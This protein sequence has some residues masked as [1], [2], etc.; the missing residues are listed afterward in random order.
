[1]KYR[2]FTNLISKNPM[3][4]ICNV[5]I[6]ALRETPSEQSEMVNQMLFGESCDILEEQKNWAKIQMHFDNCEGWISTKQIQ[7]VSDEYLATRKTNFITKNYVSVLFNHEKMLLSLGSEVD[8]PV[9]ESK[10]SDNL[11]ES[12][13]L[14]AKEFLNVP[15]LWSGKSFFG[16]DCSGLMQLVY[17]IHEIKLPRNAC[18][19]A[20]IGEP[21]TFVE[22]S[23]PGDIAFF[24]NTEG[25]IVHVGM[26]LG[27]QQ[28]IHASGKVRIDILD[29]TGIYN[30][31]LKEY[32]HKLR[33]VKRILND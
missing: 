12:I 5:S 19:Q 29:S 22:E 31:E 8:V 16:I 18:Q 7:H 32:T 23:L 2:L 1:M 27:N 14:T 26:M 30:Q 15:Y 33:F 4:A 20:E 3:K 24:E 17:K 25:K 6:A 28:I 11:R 9:K 10:R 13:V 21:L